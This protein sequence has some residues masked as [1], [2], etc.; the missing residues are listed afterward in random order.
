MTIITNEDLV[1]TAQKKEAGRTLAI[2]GFGKVTP[3]A[4][5]G[6][7]GNLTNTRENIR[8]C[9][10]LVD[11]RVLNLADEYQMRES[12]GEEWQYKAARLVEWRW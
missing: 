9:T 3:M 12:I 11:T 2:A 8:V 6:S 10:F 5:G 1:I 7:E 4:I